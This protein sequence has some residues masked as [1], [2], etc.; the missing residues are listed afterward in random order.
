MS[1]TCRDIMELKA[2]E[3][4][5]LIGGAGGLDNVVRWPYIKNVDTITEWIHGG[6]LVFVVGS[7]E[8]IS[9]QGL[10]RLM[11]EA[12]DSRIAGVVM[13]IGDDYIRSVPRSVI[14][15]ANEK[16]LPLF[17][18]PFLLKLIDMTQEI[19]KYIMQDWLASRE[20]EEDRRT[21]L[22]TLLLEG[23]AREDILSYCFQKLQ[24]LEEA[25]R[26]TKSEYVKTLKCYLEC[27][28]DLLHASQKMYI[29]RNTMIN[30]MK[31]INALLR[32]DMN[33]PE[34]RNEYWNIFQA[35]SYYEM[36]R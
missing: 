31:K 18:M 14:R 16:S 15:Y 35:M 9:E 22:L 32:Q 26:I 34:V 3:R 13:L 24:P 4:L 1:V 25:D 33:V 28:N 21:S 27:G 11:K 2:C 19:S 10:L 17:K 20:H 36:E 23:A 12:A 7:R 30:R 5:K 8:D 29:H 6:E